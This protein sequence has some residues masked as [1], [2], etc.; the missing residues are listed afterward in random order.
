M[1]NLLK[2]TLFFILSLVVSASVYADR[3]EGTI[4]IFESNATVAPFFNDSYAYA[5]FPSVGKGGFGIGGSYGK[6]K[7]YVR[8]KEAGDVT[9]ASLSI[10]F[11]LGGQAFSEIIFLKDERAFDEF[12]A[13]SFELDATASAVAITAGAQA[14]AGTNSGATV[15]ASAGPATAAQLDA[16]YTKGMAVFTHTIGGLMYEA[17]VGGQKFNFTPLG[18]VPTEEESTEAAPVET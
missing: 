8:H 13:G 11:Q 12:T 4:L 18:G 17:S 3:F 14:R 2:P 5:V 10:G 7:V 6:G 9:L 16:G 1:R 15:N